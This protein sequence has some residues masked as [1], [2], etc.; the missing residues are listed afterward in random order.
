MRHFVLSKNR[1]TEIGG[2]IGQGLSVGG[3]PAR[4][5]PVDRA[6]GT[7]EENNRGI[8]GVLPEPYECRLKGLDLPGSVRTIA[9]MS[10]LAPKKVEESTQEEA[11]TPMETVVPSTDSTSGP[12]LFGTGVNLPANGVKGRGRPRTTENLYERVVKALSI[13][14]SFGRT[15]D[16]Y[17]RINSQDVPQGC[18]E[19]HGWF[20]F[21]NNVPVMACTNCAAKAG[22]IM[23]QGARNLRQSAPSNAFKEDKNDAIIEP[24]LRAEDFNS[25]VQNQEGQ[26]NAGLLHKM[27]DVLRG[28]HDTALMALGQD[29]EF[30]RRDK[31]DTALEADLSPEYREKRDSLNTEQ[32]NL[33]DS[34]SADYRKLLIKHGL[35]R[36]L[37]TDKMESPIKS[38]QSPTDLV[39]QQRTLRQARNAQTGD[40]KALSTAYVQARKGMKD[41]TSRNDVDFLGSLHNYLDASDIQEPRTPEDIT[42]ST[43]SLERKQRLESALRRSSYGLEFT[44]SSSYPKTIDHWE[45]LIKEGQRAGDFEE[46][47]KDLVGRHLDRMQDIVDRRAGIERDEFGPTLREE[48][49]KRRSGLKEN[50]RKTRE[51]F[52][53]R[54]GSIKLFNSRSS[55]V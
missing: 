43:A 12:G 21:G 26:Q 25:E 34:S 9:D 54:T 13:G 38:I 24:A 6:F 20:N 10:R 28:A 45:K 32:S 16:V 52:G 55:N 3:G 14:S 23:L 37:D 53:I 41:P 2:L 15:K 5:N 35:H 30:S 8:Q 31:K 46:E 4:A 39:E 40:L 47:H 18:S 11:T 27:R 29:P 36:Y 48:S 1:K 17:H 22:A 44:A 7:M 42:K 33:L 49:E 19:D 50:I 51:M